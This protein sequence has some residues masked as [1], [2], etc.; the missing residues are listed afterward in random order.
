MRNLRGRIGAR[1]AQSLPRA[2]DVRQ[3][4]L[5]P[6]LKGA[7]D[8]AGFT[9]ALLHKAVRNERSIYS[10]DIDGCIALDVLLAILPSAIGTVNLHVPLCQ[11]GDSRAAPA[12]READV[13]SEQ[14]HASR[15]PTTVAL[16]CTGTHRR[17][18]RQRA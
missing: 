2:W 7:K 12:L 17:D 16:L 4:G 11:A 18:G 1:C 6:L 8:E 14:L 3:T 5:T 9:G 13:D 10:R 15:D